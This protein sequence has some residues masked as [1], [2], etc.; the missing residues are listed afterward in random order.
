ME[1]APGGTKINRQKM[2]PQGQPPQQEQGPP[3]GYQGPPPGYQG[4]PPGYQ[5]PPPGYQGPPPQ[6]Q[7]PQMPPMMIPPTAFGKSKSRFGGPENKM[8]LKY[9]ILVFLIFIILNSKI[10]WKQLMTIP[11]L[12]G[13]EPSIM[14]LLV[15]SLI[16]GILFFIISKYVI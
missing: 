7:R 9:S 6:Q 8:Y 15:N 10:I 4:P 5:G 2:P 3:P 14:S 12:S 1:D 13:V 16:A 11:G